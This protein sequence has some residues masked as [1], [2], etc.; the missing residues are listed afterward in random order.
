MRSIG[1]C[2]ALS[3]T[4]QMGT[5]YNT[6]YIPHTAQKGSSPHDMSC[7]SKGTTLCQSL[8]GT[9]G[10]FLCNTNTRTLHSK[11]ISTHAISWPKSYNANSTLL[12]MI[13]YDGGLYGT[14]HAPAGLAPG[15]NGRLPFRTWVSGPETGCMPYPS[16]GV[17]GTASPPSLEQ[18]LGGLDNTHAWQRVPRTIS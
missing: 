18:T 1:G 5:Q 11:I 10:E 12:T 7:P 13:H 14:E 15:I 8:I 17:L 3:Q 6:W 9:Q 2:I 4:R 16:H